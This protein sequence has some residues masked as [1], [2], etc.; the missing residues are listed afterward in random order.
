MGN[1]KNLLVRWMI[2]FLISVFYKQM[3]LQIKP[4]DSPFLQ[5][6]MITFAW[7]MKEINK[8]VACEKK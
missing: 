1:N 5:L 4:Q 3:R 6:S 2:I 7:L 8:T